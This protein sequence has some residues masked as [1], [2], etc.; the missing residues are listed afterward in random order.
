MDKII[1]TKVSIISNGKEN[2]Y[3]ISDNSL[4]LKKIKEI[5][6]SEHHDRKYKDKELRSIWKELEDKSE[7]EEMAKADKR[8]YNTQMKD[9][10]KA[11][12]KYE[13]AKLKMRKIK[14]IL[15][16][17]VNFFNFSATNI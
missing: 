11:K 5:Y 9:Y 1:K 8:R 3:K 16:N 10:E 4:F 6:I 2:I 14:M 7:Y 12:K 15:S 13:K 17:F